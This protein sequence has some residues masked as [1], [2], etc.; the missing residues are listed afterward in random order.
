MKREH[1]RPG[2]APPS[3]ENVPLQFFLRILY[4]RLVQLG[5]VLQDE[6]EELGV[7]AHELWWS[8]RA[9]DIEEF[10]DG[11]DQEENREDHHGRH[12]S[13]ATIGTT[14]NMT[15]SCLTYRM[16]GSAKRRHFMIVKAFID[17]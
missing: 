1:E 14:L 11:E 9:G 4:S 12:L 5:A 13:F 10:E 16:G 17:R 7:T 3:G 8:W 6:F 15:S 2:A